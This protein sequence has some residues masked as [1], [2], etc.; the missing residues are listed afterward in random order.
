MIELNRHIEILLLSNDCVI[1]PDFGGFLTHY[2]SAN[3]IESEN[4]FL[5]PT[6]TVGFNPLLQLNDHLLVQSYVEAYDISYPEALRRIEDEVEELRQYLDNQGYYELSGLGTLSLNSEGNYEFSPCAAGLLTPMLYGLSSFEMQPLEN[7][8]KPQLNIPKIIPLE[9]FDESIQEEK[10]EI[11]REI[12]IDE[13]NDSNIVIRMSWIRNIVATAA[14]FLLFFISTPIKNGDLPIDR[15]QS[16]FLPVNN[17][18]SKTDSIVSTV[19]AIVKDSITSEKVEVVKATP[20]SY[21]T[22]CLASQT[23]RH[24]AEPFLES[25]EKAG[26][27]DVRIV[28]MENMNKVRVVC[29]SFSS[30]AEAHAAIQRNR[31]LHN[32]FKDGWILHVKE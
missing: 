20:K 16:S 17:L 27:S 1:I 10:E 9:K 25:I 31:A 13:E 11:V 21:Y 14:V 29:G 23:M 7:T 3:Y 30:E 4:L 19:V 26:V 5:P 6:R 18:I 8:Q 32:A 2:V 28:E 24:L 12:P 22:I 15:Q